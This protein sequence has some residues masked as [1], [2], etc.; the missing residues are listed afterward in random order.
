MGRFRHVGEDVFLQVDRA[1]HQLLVQAVTEFTALVEDDS[2]HSHHDPDD[3]FVA[4]EKSFGVEPSIEDVGGQDEPD[5]VTRRLFPAAYPGDPE[6]SSDF[7]RFT[8][9]E[10]RRAKRQAADVVLEDLHRVARGQALVPRD[11]LEPWLKTLNNL[12]LV[13]SVILGITDEVS[14]DEAAQRPDEDPRS[15]LFT[16]YSWLGWMLESLLDAFQDA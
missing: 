1:E 6:A 14:N 5:P 9:A 8:E 12:R 2:D 16:F 7:R 15:W 11:H 4:W 13:L 3:P 10:Q